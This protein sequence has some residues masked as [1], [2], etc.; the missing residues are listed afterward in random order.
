M[1]ALSQQPSLVRR[2]QQRAS[3]R[4]GRCARLSLKREQRREG[5][6]EGSGRGESWAGASPPASD[7][8]TSSPRARRRPAHRTS[9]SPTPAPTR[10]GPCRRPMRALRFRRARRG[11]RAAGHWVRSEWAPAAVISRDERP[12]ELAVWRP[13]QTPSSLGHVSPG[14]CGLACENVTGHRRHS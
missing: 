7:A 4:V 12:R 14:C 6:G 3:G 13:P 5:G 8:T 9:P 2:A 1:K 11:A 10:G